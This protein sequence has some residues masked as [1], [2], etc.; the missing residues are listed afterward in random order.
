[1]NIKFYIQKHGN[2]FAILKKFSVETEKKKEKKKIGSKSNSSNTRCLKRMFFKTNPTVPKMTSIES[3][4][5][6][7]VPP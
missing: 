2:P 5:K 3:W 4:R 7:N 6:P 1:M